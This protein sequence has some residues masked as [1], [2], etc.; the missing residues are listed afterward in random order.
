MEFDTK[1]ETLRYYVNGQDQGIAVD[2]D[3]MQ[4]DNKEFVA[5]ISMNN[6]VIVELLR[7]EQKQE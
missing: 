6:A 3:F 4:I 7:F 5:A 1:H 2:K